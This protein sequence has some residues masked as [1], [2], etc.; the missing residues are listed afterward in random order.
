[1]GVA[2]NGAVRRYRDRLGSFVGSGMIRDADARIPRQFLP[3][4]DAN[5]K[6]VRSFWRG[7]FCGAVGLAILGSFAGWLS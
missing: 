7:V 1:M 2:A 5:R 6:A 3:L 4:D